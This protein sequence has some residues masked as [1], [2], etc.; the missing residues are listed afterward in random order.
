MKM[1]MFLLMSFLFLVFSVHSTP[2]TAQNSPPVANAGPDQAVLVGATVFLN[3][4][5][6]TDVDGDPLTF[7]WSLISIPPGSSTT[8]VNPTTVNPT[9]VVDNPGS[10]VVQLIV[11]DGVVDSAPDTVTISTAISSAISVPTMTEWGVMLLILILGLLAIYYLKKPR[12]AT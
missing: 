6:S 1:K 8:L 5:G 2:A 3:G 10:Y 4:S 11:N 7:S 9:F 12:I